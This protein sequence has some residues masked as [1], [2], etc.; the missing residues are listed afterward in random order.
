ML[1][2]MLF[3]SCEVLC[4]VT[5]VV[6][7]AKFMYCLKNTAHAETVKNRARYAC[8]G[9]LPFRAGLVAFLASI[10]VVSYIWEISFFTD[11]VGMLATSI[12]H[13]MVFVYP[14]VGLF[15]FGILVTSVCDLI[16]ANRSNP[17]EESRQ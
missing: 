13:S 5:I 14:G 1:S 17:S 16:C 7:F 9:M 10:L 11:N 3:W 8:L 15:I 2:T 4:F 6:S 12:Q